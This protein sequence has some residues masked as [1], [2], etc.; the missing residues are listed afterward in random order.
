MRFEHFGIDPAKHGE[1]KEAMLKAAHA[2]VEEY[3]VLL[4]SV[5][6]T[7]GESSPPHALAAFY[8]YAMLAFVGSDGEQQEALPNI[9][10]HHCELLHALVLHLSAKEW[11]EAPLT[12]DTMETLF[13][14]IP[15]LSNTFFMQRILDGEDKSGN[16]EEL[17]ILSLQERVRMHTHGVRNWGY[18]EQVVQTS[19][20]LYSDL[21]ED[22]RSHY[23]FSATD[24]IETLLALRSEFED[25]LNA[26][27]ELR[28]KILRG[29]TATEL[30][31]QYYKLLPD[32]V[33]NAEEML[34]KLPSDLS[35]EQMAAILMSYL[36]LRLLDIGLFTTESTAK[37]TGKQKEI[38]AAILDSLSFEPGALAEFKPEYLFL[39]NPVWER[40]VIFLSGQ[41]FF[42]MPQIAFSHIHRI[43]ERFAEEVGSKVSL[44]NRRAEFLEQ[45]LE[46]LFRNALPDA[47]IYPAVKWK[48]DGQQFETDLIAVIDR[49]VVIAEAKSNR[50]TPSGLRGAPE[51]VKRHVCDIVVKPSLQSKRLEE[52]IAAARDGDKEART[53]LA[54][55]GID[56]QK[57]DCVIRLSVSLYDLSVLSS[58][59]KELKKIGWVP[60]D[61]DL[62]PSIL[63]SNLQCVADI[64]DNPLLFLHYLKE[65]SYFQKIHNLMGDELDFLGIYLE[66]AFNISALSGENLIVTEMSA[67]VDKYYEAITLGE[68]RQKPKMNL[69]PLFRRIISHLT[70]VKP[71]GW[72]LMGFHLLAC[73]APDKQRAIERNLLKLRKSVK[74][75]YRDPKHKSALVIKP[76]EARKATVIFY[77]FPKALRHKHREIMEQLAAETLTSGNTKECVV[78]SRCTDDWWRQA[79]ESTLLARRP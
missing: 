35:R 65:R 28:R 13:E 69:R 53:I 79:L 23:G 61:H 14:T 18:F 49:V 17:T 4:G 10:Q 74:R 15:K 26:H 11:G 16:D 55:I 73:A 58:S 34:A 68:Q 20:E 29:N 21:D 45:Q 44:E 5:R 59:E 78:F 56:A 72:T 22:M 24:L 31:E 46:A 1:F 71:Q 63:I 41:Y 40:P 30:A 50:L 76:P 47:D 48:K 7:L 42:P 8:C 38:V 77:L 54:G 25:R 51:R 27:M 12:P 36:D 57:A 62:A 39:D 3:P 43:M 70:K 60:E 67:A 37:I 2:A 32:I 33:G 6:A 19:Q 66:S 75:N 9:Q 64:L 52:V